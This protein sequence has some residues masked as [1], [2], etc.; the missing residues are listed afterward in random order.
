MDSFTSSKGIQFTDLDWQN[1]TQKVIKF[2]KMDKRLSAAYNTETVF[3]GIKQYLW[4]GLLK[5]KGY[6]QDVQV[7]DW[8]PK[9]VKQAQ[10]YLQVENTFYYS[11]EKALP[12]GRTVAFLTEQ[13]KQ[14]F[15]NDLVDKLT[16]S[17]GVDMF[18][19]KIKALLTQTINKYSDADISVVS[20][21]RKL[22]LDKDIE[23]DF[24]D[25][26]YDTDLDK[27]KVKIMNALETMRDEMEKLGT[28]GNHTKFAET[29]K[30]H[31][32]RTSFDPSDFI[33]IWNGKYRNK[34]KTIDAVLFNSDSIYMKGVDEF[35]VYFDNVEGLT[36]AQKKAVGFLVHKNALKEINPDGI[37]ITSLQVVKMK[38][39]FEAMYMFSLNRLKVYPIIRF[40]H[41]TIA[42]S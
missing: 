33:F 35:S 27:K 9:T 29:N 10:Q 5:K 17:L 6:E 16:D 41:K 32:F 26:A 19:E 15:M 39:I 11:F 23:V 37:S 7:S 3:N 25:P 14:E 22:E 28:I 40:K 36:A 24:W 20:K 2:L 12:K 31:R 38:R 1:V 13:E 34:V 42:S 8:N 30:A 21:T 4:T 18:D